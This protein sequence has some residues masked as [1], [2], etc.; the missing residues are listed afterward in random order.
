MTVIVKNPKGGGKG[1][2]K[3]KTGREGSGKEPKAVPYSAFPTVRN[4]ELQS[5][6]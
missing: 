1:K 3:G 5:K 2:M 4:D 6:K